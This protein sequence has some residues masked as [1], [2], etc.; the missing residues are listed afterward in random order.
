MVNFWK[1]VKYMKTL[2]QLA[3]DLWDAKKAE[4]IAKQKRIEAEEAIAA[5][6]ETT[7]TGSKT[8]PA[9][10]NLKV[11]V[12]RGIIFNVDVDVLRSMAGVEIPADLCPVKMT[13]PVPAGYAFDEKAYLDLK[14]HYPEIYGKIAKIV[15]TKPRKVSVELKLK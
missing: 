11:T 12:K 2:E 14:E 5:L 7:E 10:D 6:V 3:T 9:G 4:D 8:V 1:H 13:P 15:T